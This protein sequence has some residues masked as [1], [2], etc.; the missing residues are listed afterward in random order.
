M[1]YKCEC[2]GME[3]KMILSNLDL[4]REQD[5][6]KFVVGSKSDLDKMKE[7][8]NEFKLKCRVYVSPVFGM[9]EA[10]ELV[11]YVLDNKLN[12]VTVQ[13]QLHK[14]IWNPDMRGV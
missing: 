1:D 4:L 11:E 13:V 5:V 6:L 9:I 12:N 14:I 8:I 2:S 7:I 3:D 10:H